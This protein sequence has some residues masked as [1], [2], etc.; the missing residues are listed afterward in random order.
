MSRYNLTKTQMRR[1]PEYPYWDGN[2]NKSK[3]LLVYVEQGIGDFINFI[4]YAYIIRPM[5]KK[6]IA[7]KKRGKESPNLLA[8]SKKIRADVSSISGYCIEIFEPQKAHFPRKKSQE[9]RGMLCH[10]FNFA[11]QE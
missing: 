8:K 5:V 6:L 3:T 2:I 10:G 1:F 4:R 11:L 9:K 7:I